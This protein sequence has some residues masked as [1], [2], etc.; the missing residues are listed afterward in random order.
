MNPKTA[1]LINSISL[2]L[3]GIWGY[4]D[5]SSPTALIPAIFG[6]LILICF[7]LSNRNE[8][9]NKIFVHVAISLTILIL[10]ALI[11]T[12]LPK[13]IDDGGVG[14]IRV[15]IMIGTSIFS[16]VIFTKNFIDAR[17]YKS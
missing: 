3:M 17:R 2:I 9:L 1:N 13:S 14:L 16:T 11:F 6:I 7:F 10:V 8:K 12:R 15:L 5:V 4:L